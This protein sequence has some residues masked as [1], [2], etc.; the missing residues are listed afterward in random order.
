[1]SP[2]FEVAVIVMVDAPTRSE[3]QADAIDAIRAGDYVIGAVTPM[4]DG[5]VLDD[6]YEHLRDGGR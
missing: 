2:L 4:G 3:A 6:T 5:C 1:V